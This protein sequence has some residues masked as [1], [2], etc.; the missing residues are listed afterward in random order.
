MKERGILFSPDMVRA[1]LSGHKRQTRRVAR[2]MTDAT[3]YAEASEFSPGVVPIRRVH[4]PKRLRK[5]TTVTA[6]DN[7]RGFSLQARDGGDPFE[8][9]PCPYGVKGDRLWVRETWRPEQTPRGYGVRYSADHALRDI[10]GAEADARVHAAVRVA[11]GSWRSPLFMPRWASRLLLEVV[12]TRAERLKDIDELDALDEGVEGFVYLGKWPTF[13][14]G[15]IAIAGNPYPAGPV[16]GCARDAYR[17]L[18][19]RINGKTCPFES[20]PWVWVVTF[21]RVD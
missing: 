21:R 8:V 7:G 1:L 13:E 3:L 15:T 12:A 16:V 9:W 19:D 5:A 17:A 10:P 18:W 20:D 6:N 14:R 2:G 4:T 11:D